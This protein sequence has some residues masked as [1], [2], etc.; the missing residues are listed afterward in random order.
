MTRGFEIVSKYAKD[1]LQLP[2]RSTTNAAG[3]DLRAA[4]D[5][6]VAAG[7]T[8]PVLVPTGIKAYMEPDEVL[9]LVNRSSGPIKRG[10]VQPNAVGVI[11]ADYYNSDS[12]EGEIFEQFVNIGSKDYTI[13]KG[14]RICQGIFVK[15]LVVDGDTGGKEKRTG[16]FGS[17][18]G[19]TKL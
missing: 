8:K 1:N 12:H 2:E 6:V 4:K 17:T 11:D 5:V 16:G 14:D 9:L 18:D 19:D 7:N 10:L 15:Y 3:Y 13:H